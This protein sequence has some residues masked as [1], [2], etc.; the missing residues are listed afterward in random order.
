M[1]LTPQESID[2]NPFC[3]FIAMD[4]NGEWW[5]YQYRPIYILGYWR[6]TLFALV[7]KCNSEIEFNG[8][9]KDSLYEKK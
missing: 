7:E 5:F 3:R 2:Q 6:L 4:E 1:K 8:V 9:A